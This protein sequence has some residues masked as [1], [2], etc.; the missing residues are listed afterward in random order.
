MG[1]APGMLVVRGLVKSY[2]G[3]VAVSEVA[4]EVEAGE[5]VGLVGPNGA[6][7]TTVLGCVSGQV[8]PDAGAI[9]LDGRDLRGLP[10]W[11]RARLGMGRTFQRVELFGDLTV[12]EHLLVA[13]RAGAGGAWLWR[14]L[15]GRGA[16]S[17]AERART[18]AV[19]DAVGL[20]DLAEVRVAALGLG[21][22]RLVEIA[23]AIAAEPRL[24]LADEPSS[25]LDESETRELARV[26]RSLQSASGLAVLLVEHD[27]DMVR[28]VADRVLVM[29]LGRV[30][31]QG[32]FE[33]V[34][35]AEPVRRAYLGAR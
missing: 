20:G 13:A 31:A 17:A 28:A 18:D 4:F 27:L 8:R 21:T 15:L 30:V 11:R 22:C 23:R 19:L 12:R 35:A 2:G 7:K 33:D 5:T 24:L 34:M 9:E 6:G 32:G 16:I 26:L 29:D 3:T 10:A 25:G 14:D 1:G